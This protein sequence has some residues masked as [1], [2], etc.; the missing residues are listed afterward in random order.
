MSIDYAIWKWKEKPASITAGLCYLLLAEGI[1]CSEVA[2]L[3]VEKLSGQIETAFPEI[4]SDTGDFPL[5][6]EILPTGI[7]L[8]AYGSTPTSTLEW[9]VTLADREGL[10]FFDPQDENSVSKADEKELRRRS[11]ALQAQEVAIRQERKLA[12]LNARASEGSPK[13]LF[14]LGNRYSFGEGVKKDPAKAFALFQLS[15]QEGYGDG[16]FNL[17]ACYRFGE[18]VQRD[19]DSAIAWYER[20]SET[21]KLFGPFALGEIYAKGEAGAVDRSKAVYYLQLAWENGNQDAVGLLKALDA[22][23]PPE[24]RSFTGLLKRWFKGGAKKVVPCNPSI[25]RTPGSRPRVAD[26]ANVIRRRT[27]PQHCATR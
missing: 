2:P 12:E 18:G 25:Q 26:R 23:P 17:A 11:K 9:F 15:A 3:E 22:L 20:A 7:L 4:W 10:V 27:H 1:E 24:P 6:C 14:E 19:M 16:M 21:D 5:S 13:A 8:E